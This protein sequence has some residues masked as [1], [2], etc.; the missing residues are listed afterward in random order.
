MI[1]KLE[2]AKACKCFGRFLELCINDPDPEAQDKYQDEFNCAN[3][4]LHPI[5]VKIA[6]VLDEG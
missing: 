3:C 6:E 5:C 1:T 4:E 2:S